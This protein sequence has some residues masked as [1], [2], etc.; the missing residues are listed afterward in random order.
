MM[1]TIKDV[2]REAGLSV[3]TVSRVL[4]GRGYLSQEAKDRVQ[5]AMHR[6][7]Y[8]PNALARSL[9]KSSSRIVAIIMPMLDNPFFS[10]LLMAITGELSQRGYQSLLF[11][12]DS[13]EGNVSGF[14]RECMRN[15]VAGII[16]CSGSLTSDDLGELSIPVVT[17]ER[18]SLENASRIMCDNRLGGRLAAEHLIARGCRR[19]LALSAP[20]GHPMPGD[21]RMEAFLETCRQAGV[22]CGGVVLEA[23]LFHSQD[24]S[25]SI[26]EVLARHP[27]CDGL[28][29]TSDMLAVQA[30]GVACQLG[31]RIPEDLKV[32]GFDGTKLARTLR[33]SLTTVAQP[34]GQMARLA[35][36]S[37]IEA[38]RPSSVRV[39]MTV[40]VRLV[41]GDSTMASV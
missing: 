29:C 10:E 20:Q 4:N 1:S 23:G 39:D 21:E 31:R 40:E 3:G 36:E 26:E 28:F 27:D 9:S 12:C 13:R 37:V 34:T 2:A 32:V 38:A 14:M 7:G 6:L 33:P 25:A 24:Y 8:E 17:L 30:M 15:R 16:L 5:A 11:V 35:V 22:D 18:G 19:L 41:E